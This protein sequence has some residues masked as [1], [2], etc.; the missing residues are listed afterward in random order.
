MSNYFQ[1]QLSQKTEPLN[2]LCQKYQIKTLY[3]FGSATGERFTEN[4]D[5]DFLI[6]FEDIPVEDYADYFFDF[7]HELESLFQRKIDLITEQSLTNP[8]LIKS[9]N[10][11]K[12]LL[13]DRR[14][15]KIPA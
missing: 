6:T 14:N 10:Q 7:M 1:S 5:L 11:N 8:F 2:A 15:Q 4:S 13:Y 12:L 9:I 3:L